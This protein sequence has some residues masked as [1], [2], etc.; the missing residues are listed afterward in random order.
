MGP[1]RWSRISEKK[2]IFCHLYLNYKQID[3]DNLQ[4][5]KLFKYIIYT[6]IYWNRPLKVLGVP[7]IIFSRNLKTKIVGHALFNENIFKMVSLP[8]IQ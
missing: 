7:L 5:S 8:V 4:Y 6:V 3:L 1:S 2:I